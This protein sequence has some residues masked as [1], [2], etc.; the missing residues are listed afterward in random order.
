MENQNV[1]SKLGEE[2]YQMARHALGVDYNAKYLPN[3]FFRNRYCAS[4]GQFELI[5]N[6]VGAGYARYSESELVEEGQKWIFFT[7]EGK[8]WFR[9]EFLKVHHREYHDQL[10]C[11]LQ[12]EEKKQLK[13]E[14]ENFKHVLFEAI[15]EQT[16]AEDASLMAHEVWSFH[17]GNLHNLIGAYMDEAVTQVMQWTGSTNKSNDQ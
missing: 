11:D 14:A 10:A 17:L 13:V 6:L 7:E 1:E 8:N 12:R 15:E 9:S 2:H 16:I 5:S 4:K 3:E